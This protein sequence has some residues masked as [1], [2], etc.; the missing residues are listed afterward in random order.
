MNNE[1]LV[2]IIIPTFNR[3]PKL[4]DAIES[5]INQTY[6]YKQIIVI[7]DGS[8]DDTAELVKK[9]PQVEYHYKEN[10]GQASARNEGLKY[11]K[12]EI[13]ASLDSDDVWYPEFLNNCITK[14]EEENL[15]FVFA[16]WEQE[17]RIGN[18]WDFLSSDPFLTPYFVKEKDGW[19]ILEYNEVRDL[20]IKSCPSPSSS[21]VIKRSSILN[22]WDEEMNIGDDWCMYLELILSRKC[23]VGFTLQKLW[24]K[25]ID[26]INIYDGRK[27]SEVLEF[28]YIADVKA[29]IIKFKHLLTP[30][31]LKI[32]EERYMGGLV[33]FAKHNLIRELNFKYSFN[34]LVR[35][36]AVNIPFTLREIPKVLM[37]GLHGKVLPNQKL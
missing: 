30:K 6:K 28:L 33:E 12:G 27:W 14:L 35:S 31:E 29:K 19:I 17:S 15:D 2:T 22:G 7:D 9:Y 4:I 32:L 21:V 10:G 26:E 34:L 18:P 25:R 1:N 36:F 24:K 16:N 20:F 11:A 5:A 37:K 8:I 13:I 3:A 23:R